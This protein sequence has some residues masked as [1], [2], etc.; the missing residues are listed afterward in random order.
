MTPTIKCLLREKNHLMKKEQLEKA[1]ALAER[2]GAMIT[3][4]NTEWLSDCD[5][6][7]TGGAKAMWTKVNEITGSKFRPRS[8]PPDPATLNLH[9]A[10]TPTDAHYIGPLLKSSCTAPS[11]WPSN[12]SVFY[13]LDHL[14]QSA[15]GLDGLLT[16]FL[17]LAAPGISMPLTYLFRLSM[18][19][20][21]VPTQWK[22]ACITRVPKVPAAVSCSD[23]SPISITPVLLLC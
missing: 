16:W 11:S 14:K 22:S 3:K 8:T 2:I 21:K 5:P 4:R 9:Y 10:A 1:S 18:G 13:A 20:S 7:E 17:R 19:E 6:R 23:F 15:T 12:Q